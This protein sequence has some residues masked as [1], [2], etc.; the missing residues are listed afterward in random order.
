M[1]RNKRIQK[2]IE[3]RKQTAANRAKQEPEAPQSEPLRVE[4]LP[5]DRVLDTETTPPSAQKDTQRASAEPDAE[6]IGRSADEP[7][8]DRTVASACGPRA[9][10]S[11]CRVETSLSKGAARVRIAVFHSDAGL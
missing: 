9:P 6:S 8:S 7:A 5:E 1:A 2:T 3:V 11:L 10:G 4:N